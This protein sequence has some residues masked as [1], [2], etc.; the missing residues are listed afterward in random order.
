VTYPLWTGTPDQFQ[1]DLALGPLY[2]DRPPTRGI[3][4]WTD[5]SLG[6]PLA[7]GLLSGRVKAV[8]GEKL[9]IAARP[10]L[11][12]GKVLLVGCRKPAAD[13]SAAT[14]IAERFAD[15]MQGL[16]ADRILIEVPFQDVEFFLAKFRAGLG[17][18]AP[19]EIFAYLPESPCRI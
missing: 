4:G 12:V 5:W 10:P 13:P 11:G 7:D 19:K 18:D 3:A 14:E 9:L 17:A 1:G 16:A 6:E 15:A 8:V 2:A